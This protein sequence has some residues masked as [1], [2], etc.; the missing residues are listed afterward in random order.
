[1]SSNASIVGWYNFYNN[2]SKEG[3]YGLL[4]NAKPNSLF[5]TYVVKC[6]I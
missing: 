3:Y 6:V 5:G 2:P 1:M 4:S